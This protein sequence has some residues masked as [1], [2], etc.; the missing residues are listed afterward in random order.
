MI[1]L[2]ENPSLETSNHDKGD[3]KIGKYWGKKIGILHVSGFW[4][5]EV[6]LLA[7]A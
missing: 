1:D 4:R 6:E 5:F 3:G 2:S 7:D